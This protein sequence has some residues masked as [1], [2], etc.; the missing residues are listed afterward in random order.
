MKVLIAAGGTAG[1]VFP[2]L[3]VAERLT[4]EPGVQVTF[5]GTAGGQEA[6]L[7]PGAGFP[8]TTVDARPLPRRPSPAALVALAAAARAVSASRALVREAD[9]V[10]GMG[11]YVS[12]P[13]GLAARSL[14][15]PL[16]LHEQNAVPGLANR[17]LARRA[18]AVCLSFEEAA[19]K[20]PRGA[21][22]VLTGD[23]VRTRV[24][25]V[26]RERERLAAEAW[27]ALGLDPALRTVLI[28][29]GSQGARRLNEAAASAASEL[30]RAEDVQVL[31]LCGP[32]HERAVA[33]AMGDRPRVRVVGFLER[34]ELAYAAADLAVARAGASTCAEL[35]V[36][37]IPAVLVPYPYATARHQE[38]NARALA[39]A[40]GAVVLSDAD[41]SGTR[42]VRVVRDLLGD[43]ERMRAMS[44]AMRAWARPDAADA[45]AREVLRAGGRG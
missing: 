20:L 5:V 19:A 37:G 29:G 21:R 16:V 28:V 7:V 2:A 18:T 31:L 26:A 22:S 8:F 45:V 34:M 12:L 44:A 4:E 17:V 27:T 14:G 10:V 41:L 39:R 33:A 3:A 30:A 32:A 35:A 42:L 36:C 25:A 23:P 13:V 6:R 43:P 1:H 38:A 9:V 15:R 40:G 11:G 24:L